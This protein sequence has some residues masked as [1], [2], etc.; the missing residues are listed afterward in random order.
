MKHILTPA[1]IRR[2]KD[3][4]IAFL[5]LAIFTGAA[6]RQKE[7][8]FGLSLL[9]LILYVSSLYCLELLKKKRPADTKEGPN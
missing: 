8:A 1:N 6:L 3:V 4:S 7:L 5:V 2:I 9:C